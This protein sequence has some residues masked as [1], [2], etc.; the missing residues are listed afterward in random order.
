MREFPLT[1]RGMMI[2]KQSGKHSSTGTKS[3]SLHLDN[4]KFFRLVKPNMSELEILT[5][6]LQA[7]RANILFYYFII[8]FYLYYY[9]LLIFLSLFGYLFSYHGRLAT[10]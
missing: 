1:N 7:S 6:E 10:L 8:L 9:F 5:R 4:T 3:F 2:H